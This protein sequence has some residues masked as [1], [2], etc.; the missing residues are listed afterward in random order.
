MKLAG[1][2]AGIDGAVLVALTVLK[3]LAALKTICRCMESLE[4]YANE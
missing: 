4:Y 2:I 1:V 3:L